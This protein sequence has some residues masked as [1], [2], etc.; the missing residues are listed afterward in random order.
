MENG[1][2]PDCARCGKTLH[3]SQKFCPECGLPASG[4]SVLSS[5]IGQLR[6]T[7]QIE[8]GERPRPPWRRILVPTASAIT[9]AIVLAVGLMLFNRPLVEMVFPQVREAEA[10][11]IVVRPSWEPEWVAIPAGRFH[12]FEPFDIVQ[13]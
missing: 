3:S 8:S 1:R 10:A 11:P 9:V 7:Q 12:R 2:P 4:G 13:E 6:E 5:E